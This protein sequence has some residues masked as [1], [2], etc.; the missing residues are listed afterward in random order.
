MVS[1]ITV[2][3]LVIRKIAQKWIPA[4]WIY[5]I[6]LI[7]LIMGFLPLLLQ[8]DNEGLSNAAIFGFGGN[9]NYLSSYDGISTSMY[10]STI[11][12]ILVSLF[13]LAKYVWLIGSIVVLCI[14]LLR[15][16]KFIK[17]ANRWCEPVK[18]EKIS[19]ILREKCKELGIEKQIAIS[20]CPFVISP[21]LVG[22]RKPLILIPQIEYTE[23]ELNFIIQHECI[24]HKRKDIAF[25]YLLL[26]ITAIQWFNPFIYIFTGDISL[27][28]EISCDDQVIKRYDAIKR[29]QYIESI[30]SIIQKNIIQ[31]KTPLSTNYD[32]GKKA[33]ERRILSVM[34]RDTKKVSIAMVV[35]II[36]VVGLIIASIFYFSRFINFNVSSGRSSI[37]FLSDSSTVSGFQK[38]TAIYVEENTT[39]VNMKGKVSTDGTATLQLISDIDGTVVFTESYSST[40]NKNV[41]INVQGLQPNS[42]YTL[43]FSSKDAN[44]GKLR[45]ESDQ[46]LTKQPKEPEH[47]ARH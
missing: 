26:I 27:Q 44:M 45:L 1:L 43:I 13:N 3:Y 22:L 37:E 2:I 5:Y 28:C 31:C 12:T 20:Y 8:K 32:G 11:A 19:N 15:H 4:K 16:R 40:K 47:P 18:S 39:T 29:K 30:I 9:T 17:T 41:S 10:S 46:S 14:C 38:E 6:G 34:N 42:Y 24:H 7:L 36:A 25:K 35:C 21:L 33:M 23:N